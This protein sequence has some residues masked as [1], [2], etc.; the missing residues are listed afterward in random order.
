LLQSFQNGWT[1]LIR[2]CKQPSENQ[3][4]L[5]PLKTKRIINK[6]ILLIRSGP[7]HLG[8]I[9]QAMVTYWH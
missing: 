1:N 8:L 4:D 5:E 2:S 9:W 3:K 7:R 6:F